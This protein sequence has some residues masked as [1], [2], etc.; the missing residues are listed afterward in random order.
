MS[1]L[2]SA[3]RRA[4]AATHLPRIADRVKVARASEKMGVAETGARRVKEA[5]ES[6]VAR[7]QPTAIEQLKPKDLKRLVDEIWLH[8][9]LDDA[10]ALALDQGV[11]R[12]RK[13]IDRTII[14]TYLRNF[15]TEHPAFDELNQA[16]ASVADRHD[17]PWRE[18]GATW[19]LW[20]ASAGPAH[21]AR[22]LL[23]T[24]TP[25][26]L[27]R[28]AGLDG[29]LATGGF[30]EEALLAACE[31]TAQVQ[32]ERA[33]RFGRQLIT[34]FDGFPASQELNAGLTFALLAPWTRGNCSEAHQRAISSLLVARSGDPRLNPA[35]WSALRRDVLNLFPDS[36]VDDAFAVLRRWLIEGSMRAFFEIVARTTENRRQW[37]E[38]TEFWLAYLDAKVISDAW[39][40]LGSRARFLVSRLPD[41]QLASS[42]KL[43]GGGEFGPKSTLVLTLG[44]LRIVEWSDNGK[45]R[46]WDGNDPAAAQ[47]YKDR[48]DGPK[49]RELATGRSLIEISHTANWQARFARLIYHRTGVRHP[50][51]GMGL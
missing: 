45:V 11:S 26:Q 6:F 38:R 17:W 8:E 33:E 30:V 46:I 43:D 40:A 3:C 34:L 44:D 36:K 29:D 31:E 13:S 39:F 2:K 50:K 5:W 47:Q 49:L 24:D 37:R 10:A 35:S 51:H 14:A 48:Y 28:D 12:K 23:D 21:L 4:S 19:K 22:A 25:I 20:D 32:G 27:L 41:Q 1:G 7:I 15:P 9:A 18:R 16:S 42:G